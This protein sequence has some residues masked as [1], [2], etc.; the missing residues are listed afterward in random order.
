MMAAPV[1]GDLRM[2]HECVARR[3]AIA[4][5]DIENACRNASTDCEFGEAQH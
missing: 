1:L 5:H 4:L 2:A 3:A